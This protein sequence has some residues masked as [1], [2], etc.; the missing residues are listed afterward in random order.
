MKVDTD[1]LIKELVYLDRKIEEIDRLA[2]ESRSLINDWIWIIIESKRKK[3]RIIG[4]T[5]Q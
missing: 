5:S 2:K 3:E 1:R 4:K